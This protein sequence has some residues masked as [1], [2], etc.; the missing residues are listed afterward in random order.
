[1]NRRAQGAWAP[2]QHHHDT[3]ISLTALGLGISIPILWWGE[4]VL[5]W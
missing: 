2:T 5:E 4:M 1:M 3:G